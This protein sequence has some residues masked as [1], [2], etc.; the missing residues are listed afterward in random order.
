VK[1]D[2]TVMLF[3]WDTEALLCLWAGRRPSGAEGF[4]SAPGP[5]GLRR[6]LQDV[7]RFAGS[8]RTKLALRQLFEDGEAF[9]HDDIVCLR[10]EW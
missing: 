9:F 5:H 3:L 2:S 8:E 6:G 1:T 7:A 4:C 10:R